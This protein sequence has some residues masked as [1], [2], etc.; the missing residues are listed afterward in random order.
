[1]SKHKKVNPDHYKVSGREKPGG[2]GAKASR[3]ALENTR[4][5]LARWSG[6]GAKKRAERPAGEAAAARKKARPA[7]SKKR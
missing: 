5:E 3:Q 1:M 2:A 7:G 6:G 4:T